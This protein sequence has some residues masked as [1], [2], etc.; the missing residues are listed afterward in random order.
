MPQN[1]LI[2]DD[3]PAQRRLLHSVVSSLGYAS[4]TAQNGVEALDLLRDNRGRA[5][6]AV[7]LDLVM[8]GKT[9]ME[10]LAELR[11]ER[12]ALP[13][14]V[15]TGNGS[16]TTVVQA[17]QTGATDFIVK[18]ASPERLQVSL[19]NALKLNALSDEVSRLTRRSEGRLSFKDLI[20]KSLVMRQAIML[21]ERAAA[22]NIPVLIE[23]E[24]GVGKEVMA[25]AIQG[26]SDRAG[27]SFVAVNCGA[28]PENLVESILFG[29]EKGA[30]TGATDKRLG[31]FQEASGGTLFLDEVGELPLDIQVKLLRALQEGEVDPVGAKKPLKVDIR[32]VSATNQNLQD[33][34]AS[35]KFREDLFYRLNVFPLTLPPLRERADDIPQLIDHFIQKFAFEEGRNVRAIED[36]ALA[37]LV[38]YDWPGNVRQLENMIY[39]AVV[40]SDRDV[41]TLH[42][43]PHLVGMTRSR[44]DSM[45][46]ASATLDGEGLHPRPPMAEGFSPFDVDGHMRTLSQ[47]EGE[48]I[49]LAIRKYDGRMSEVARRLGIGRSTLYR[50]VRELGLEVR[51]SA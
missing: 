16:V 21:A 36:S 22:S 47:V 1:I 30:F 49:E 13:V 41:L 27:K 34:V 45:T 5:V 2:V 4:T 28:I 6:D 14:I 19:R 39:R 33:L 46:P 12:P 23:G 18:P 29:H 10:V 20:A 8:P 51:E 44:D 3:D 40:L 48:M 35:G 15:L 9:G 38:E 32:L 43:F 42:D 24:S 50:K 7:L 17:M 31:K 25:R 37:L 26:A 11:P